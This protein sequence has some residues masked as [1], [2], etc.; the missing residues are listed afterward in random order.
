[1]PT[2]PSPDAE[3]FWRNLLFALTGVTILLFLK[4]AFLVPGTLRYAPF[5]IQDDARQFLAWMPRIA[6]PSLMRGDLLAHYWESVGPPLYKALF[7]GAAAIGIEPTVFARLLPPVLL[8]AAAWASWRAALKL[9]GRPASAFVA[10]GFVMALLIHEDSIWTATPRA[11]SPPLFLIFLD[12]L[13]R[14]RPVPIVAALGLLAAL[15]PTTALV[16]LTMLGFSFLRL[17]PRLAIEL[18]RRAILLVGAATLATAVP[19]LLYAGNTERWE[20]VITVEQAVA[21][22]NLGS[23]EG[24]S[25]IV[26]EDG[27]VAWICSQRMGFAPEMVPC[28][29][30]EAA[31]PINLL[32]LLP[33]VLLFLGAVRRPPPPER[34]PGE[35]VYGWALIAGLAWWAVAI[36][37]AFQLHLPARYPQRVLSILEWLAIGQLLGTWLDGR[38]RE[39]L[40][41]GA[42][43][44]AGVLALLF[45]VSFLTPTPGLRRP[46]D[47]GAIA[48]IAATP[49]GT[50]I[51]GISEDLDFVPAL[52][53]RPTLA[54]TEHAIPYHLGYFGP[55]RERLEATLA[56][57]SGD[58]ERL[59]RFVRNYQ[60]DVF[61]VERSLLEEGRVDPRYASVVPGA[62]ARAR[63]RLVESPSALQRLA[64][65]C[66]LYKGPVLILLDARCL[67]AAAAG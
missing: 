54:T 46:Q 53:G 24:R 8:F 64:P 13:L 41:G 50:T 33:L 2:L 56:A 38:L 62:A 4:D 58:G 29:A 5:T 45:L 7:R 55:V 25:S 23:A 65:R 11:F 21:M 66:A 27:S 43:V 3:H 40:K 26:N 35:L 36:A 22:P 63:A 52:A 18:T 17:R 30:T 67:A 6:D 28:W 14:S 32:L 9:T 39:G 57:A 10:A 20:P 1:M 59:S 51:A 48:R 16:G 15:Y 44:G 61:A 47:P 34:W 42:A 12:G 60:V 31:G 49:P 19:I 37:F